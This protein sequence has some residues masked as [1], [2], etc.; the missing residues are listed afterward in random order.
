VRGSVSS[1]PSANGA[2]APVCFGASRNGRVSNF[3]RPNTGGE[4]FTKRRNRMKEKSKF[5]SRLIATV[6]LVGSLC[7]VSAIYAQYATP[8]MESE[9]PFLRKKT[10]PSPSPGTNT[11]AAKISEKDKNFLLYAASSNSWEVKTG[12]SVESKLQNSSAK[13]VAAR[14]VSDHTRM[15]SELVELGKKKGLGI[16]VES[17]GQQIPGPNYDKNYLT[18]VGQDQQESI[19]RYQKEAQSADDKDVKAFAAKSLPILRQH[20]SSIKEAEGKVK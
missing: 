17:K 16:S 19:N 11:T 6:G 14:L 20:A 13:S 5:S 7:I 2:L 4:I 3:T 8:S 15:N 9:N 1:S 12:T 10:S 18:L